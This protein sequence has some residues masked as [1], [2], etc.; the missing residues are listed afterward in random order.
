MKLRPAQLGTAAIAVAAILAILGGWL[1]LENTAEAQAGLPAPA[2]VQV[3]NG[4]SPGEVTI[5][6]EEVPDASGYRIRWLHYDAASDT[7]HSDQDWKQLILSV[8]VPNGATT[9]RTV[10][11]SAPSTRTAL[12]L[13]GV[14]SLST[15]TTEPSWSA[16]ETLNVLGAVTDGDVLGAALAVAV[17]ASKLDAVGSV[18]T[19]RGATPSSLQA[20][21]PAIA[22]HKTELIQ[23]LGILTGSDFGA[24]AG[25]I[26]TLVNRL[27]SNVDL[28]QEGKPQLMRMW[29]DE[30]RQQARMDS[31]NTTTLVPA[32]T[33]SADSQFYAA[34]TAFDDE[35]FGSSHDLAE[36]NVLRYAHMHRLPSDLE[37]ANK[38]LAIAS[39]LSNPELVPRTQD[40]YDTV[41]GRIQRDYEYLL[42]NGGFTLE[43]A[44]I[45][46]TRQFL[47]AGQGNGNYFDLLTDRLELVVAEETLIRENEETLDRLLD[48]VSALA[49]VAQGLPAPAATIRPADTLGAPGV[50]A[51]AI[52]FGQS[53]AFTGPSAELGQSMRLGIRAAFHEAN[54]AGGVN[55]RMLELTTLDDGYETDHAFTN[56]LWLIQRERVFALIGAVGTPTSRAASPLAHGAG[57][58][59]IA[60][61]TG[62]QFLR[63]PEL[64]NILNLRA[65]YYQETERMVSY[66]EHLEDRNISRVAVLYQNDSYGIDGLN[67][68]RQALDRR[69]DMELVASWY[70]RRNTQAVK[71]AVYRIAKAQPDAVI[72]VGRPPSHGAHGG[73]AARAAGSGPHFH[74]RFLC[75]QQRAGG[76]AGR[77]RGRRARD[78]GG[79]FARR[80]Q[81]PR[82]E[83][84]SRRPVRLRRHRGA[85]VRLP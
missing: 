33:T 49:A 27:A 1:S 22:E 34:I 77:G 42:Q 7:F 17:Q 35:G 72:M 74:V 20:S 52:K 85:R 39:D 61:F 57:V 30:I 51:D 67:G 76:R 23:Q 32:A 31:S 69:K 80:R 63:D 25:R 16:W 38:F 46:L 71:S 59:F 83:G 79:A 36:A 9:S 82:A 28:I 66:L 5:S 50:T 3:V 48:E 4:A 29:I 70:Y 41:T 19:D 81:H 54:E 13:F 60:P 43:P 84:V 68:A 73:D 10:M 53:A 6:W 12:Y 44:V 58:P 62:A 21:A 24:R 56:T 2:N 64:T 65:S 40:L 26:E 78:A 18:A 47:A 45:P 55:G 14:G 8:D 11:V 15:D 75:G 37:L